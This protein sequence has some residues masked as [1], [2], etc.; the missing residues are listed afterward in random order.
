MSEVSQV[1]RQHRELSGLV[2]ST[3]MDKTVVVEVE[4]H[5]KHKLYGKFMWR[6]KKFFAHDEENRAKLGDQ[7]ILIE[8]R[9]MSAKKRWRLMKI[10]NKEKKGG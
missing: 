5:I 8:T 6:K 10:V 2:V 4:R 7:V 9:P 1:R 3:K